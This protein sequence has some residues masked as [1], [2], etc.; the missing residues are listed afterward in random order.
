MLATALTDKF[1]WSAMHVTAVLTQLTWSQIKVK[2]T[3]SLQQ[4]ASQS[5]I[6]VR[7]RPIGL[8]EKGV[9]HTGECHLDRA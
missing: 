8:H 3:V 7:L 9:K 5:N 4:Y 1:V 6:H 2:K